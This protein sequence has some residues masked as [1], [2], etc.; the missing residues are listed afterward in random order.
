MSGSAS[1][2]AAVSSPAAAAA[3]VSD[4]GADCDGITIMTNHNPARP[5]AA[6]AAATTAA[7]AAA[8]AAAASIPSLLEDGLRLQS[9]SS[10]NSNDNNNNYNNN[11]NPNPNNISITNSSN[12]G[13]G[14]GGGAGEL[15]QQQQQ[16]SC[17]DVSSPMI[18]TSPPLRRRRPETTKEKHGWRQ[19]PKPKVGGRAPITRRGMV[20][21]TCYASGLLM[22]FVFLFA[23]LRTIAMAK[24]VF[25]EGRMIGNIAGGLIVDP[26][27]GETDS[28]AAA[29]AA[30][31]APSP[32][33]TVL[34]NTFKRPRQLAEAVRHY[35]ACEG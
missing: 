11:N 25:S 10:N 26:D 2:A 24:V 18:A 3:A 8:A 35:A 30:A 5:S 21:W 22:A 28:S 33:F 13:G 27:F 17:R 12:V 20:L 1:L 15:Q 7:A 31:G 9:S 29:A 4:R 16:L 34:V 19:P 23:W 32:S 14:G 6:A